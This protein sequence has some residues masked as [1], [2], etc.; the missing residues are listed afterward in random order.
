[1]FIADSKTAKIVVFFSYKIAKREVKEAAILT[2][3]ADGA[4]GGWR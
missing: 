1:M 3:L 2:L 4:C